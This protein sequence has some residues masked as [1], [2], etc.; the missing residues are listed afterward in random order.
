MR[1]KTK[2]NGAKVLFIFLR[3]FRKADG[4]HYRIL[5]PVLHMIFFHFVAFDC[6]KMIADCFW[7]KMRPWIMRNWLE[8]KGPVYPVRIRTKCS[9]ASSLI[10]DRF[11]PMS[12]PSIQ[13]L[14]R[15]F[16]YMKFSYSKILLKVCLY[17]FI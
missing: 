8:Y 12:K 6:S 5:L 2:Q 3:H 13:D 7:V 4:S 11:S 9:I 14:K 16:A 10:F 15:K 17:S 1:Y